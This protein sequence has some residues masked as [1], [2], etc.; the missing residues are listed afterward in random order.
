MP[1]RRPKAGGLG[2]PFVPAEPTAAA[3][4]LVREFAPEPFFV[5]MND[6]IRQGILPA[7][8]PPGAPAPDVAAWVKVLRD[9][10]LVVFGPIVVPF[11]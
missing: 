2:P 6:Q 10:I 4:V 3:P 8:P 9:R 7:M 11:R 1:A 5:W